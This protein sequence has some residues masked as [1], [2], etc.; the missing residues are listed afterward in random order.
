MKT[1][2]GKEEVD[3]HQDGFFVS[4]LLHLNKL[5]FPTS[6]LTNSGSKGNSQFLL[7]ISRYTPKAFTK[8]R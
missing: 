4:S 5:L 2:I 3:M 6:V 1:L 7:C 8:V